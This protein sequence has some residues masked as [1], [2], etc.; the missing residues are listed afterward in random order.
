MPEGDFKQEAPTAPDLP[1]VKMAWIR[2]WGTKLKPGDKGT[3][4][5]RFSMWPSL[6]K[7]KAWEL[8][9]TFEVPDEHPRPG[10]HKR[11]TVIKRG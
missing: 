3:K 5:I 2:P 8:I 7:T 4:S 10:E 6:E 11:W 1:M 9:E